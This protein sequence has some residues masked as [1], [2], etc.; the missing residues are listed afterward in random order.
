MENRDIP[1]ATLKQDE[2]EIAKYI[3]ALCDFIKQSDTPITI[4]LQGEW[5]SGKSSF[6]KIL[7]DCLCSEKVPKENR[8][9][10]IWLNTWE[11]FL[12]ND[13]ESAVKKLIVSLLSQIEDHFK[14]YVDNKENSKRK[15][16]VSS[17]LKIVSSFAL[18]KLS[19]DG[20]YVERIF[21]TMFGDKD[22][23]Q[24]LQQVK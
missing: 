10:A 15:K 2:F 1:V 3:N 23:Q 20:Q 6:M 4:A 8:F 19:G 18:N 16:I 21:D 9:E 24:T 11:L 14:A 22:K 7:E 5:G 17:Y 12:D 13:Y